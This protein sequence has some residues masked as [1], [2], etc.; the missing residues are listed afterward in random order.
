MQP[1]LRPR[2]SRVCLRLVRGVYRTTSWCYLVPVLWVDSRCTSRLNHSFNLR[3]SR[4]PVKGR[5]TSVVFKAG[6]LELPIAKLR[7]V[8]GR[9]RS[10]A[11]RPQAVERRPM[12]IQAYHAWRANAV[13]CS[14][15]EESH[16]RRHGRSTAWARRSMC[17][18]NTVVLCYSSVKDTT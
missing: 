2:N 16:G 10:G 4:N 17:E 15:L 6:S 8:V 11:D 3:P 18:S 12:L 5:G 14:G 1:G 9:N 7:V 13:L